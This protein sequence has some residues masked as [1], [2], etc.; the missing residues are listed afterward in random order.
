MIAVA[1]FDPSSHDSGL[2]SKTFARQAFWIVVSREGSAI[3]RATFVFA[4]P[5]TPRPCEVTLT[6]RAAPSSLLFFASLLASN[7]GWNGRLAQLAVWKGV[8]PAAIAPCAPVKVSVI[9]SG[10]QLVG[11]NWK[12]GRST[13]TLICLSCVGLPCT[14][15]GKG[16]LV[17]VT[18]AVLGSTLIVE[19]TVTLPRLNVG[20]PAPW[21]PWQLGQEPA[22]AGVT[23]V[24][25]NGAPSYGPVR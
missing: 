15:V 9:A 21:A 25:P 18:A 22:T 8:D 6:R 13:V 3:G 24:I 5:A 11:L 12:A 19:R 17:I 20:K 2:A 1:M 14:N 23:T 4:M 16:S 10:L 7:I